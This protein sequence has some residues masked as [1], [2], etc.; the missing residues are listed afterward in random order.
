MDAQTT[1]F[2]A[3][4]SRRRRHISMWVIAPVSSML[5]AVATYSWHK[6]SDV[7]CTNNL[8]ALYFE[9]DFDRALRLDCA[10]LSQS[11]RAAA[12]YVLN[13]ERAKASG[14]AEDAARMLGSHPN[15]PYALFAMAGALMFE[16][17][18]G[19][20]ALKYARLAVAKRPDDPTFQWLL[21]DN[22]RLNGQF[23]QAEQVLRRSLLTQKSALLLTELAS[24]HFDLAERSGFE[25]PDLDRALATIAQATALDSK[26]ARAPYIAGQFLYRANQP[27]R[28]RAY[29][30]KAAD[31]TWSDKIRYNYWDAV[32]Q[33]FA[34]TKEQ[35][36]KIVRDDI[37]RYE[38]AGKT[39]E[40]TYQGAAY[41][42]QLLGMPREHDYYIE[43]L[44]KAFP[45]TLIGV[46][47]R[48]NRL[49][50]SIASASLTQSPSP[51]SRMAVLKELQSIAATQGLGPSRSID[52]A[53]LELADLLLESPSGNERLLEDLGRKLI[54]DEQSE[55]Q[56]AA[57]GIIAL[58]T[59]RPADPLA[60][61]EAARR[62]Q[63][64]P[65]YMRKHRME[66]VEA[67]LFASSVGAQVAYAEGFANYRRGQLDLAVQNLNEALKRDPGNGKS[68]GL[69][70]DIAQKRGDYARAE[71]W[72][73]RCSALPADPK[74]PCYNSISRMY[75]ARH[76]SERGLDLYLASLKP[77]IV[78]AVAQRVQPHVDAS[79]RRPINFNL[80]SLDGKH[81]SSASTKGKVV[82][83]IYWGIWC[84][85]ARISL[86][87]IFSYAER[88]KG[89]NDVIFV[90]V[91][92][93]R[94]LL[95]ATQWLKSQN[96]P[97]T[98]IDPA[99]IKASNIVSVP[100][101]LFLDRRGREAYRLR[102]LVGQIDTEFGKR[103]ANLRSETAP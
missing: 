63:G 64:L 87:E 81:I 82:V 47:E 43:K 10:N 100:T 83:L 13:E 16:P 95:K 5:L 88:F 26:F 59:S 76:G 41:F 56:L 55:P 37:A 79:A 21:A 4:E 24:V 97:P 50:P 96:P 69:L 72:Y 84:D 29:M 53:R 22:L 90:S 70:G 54:S 65:D 18:R 57:S 52:T 91:N 30:A 3:K 15:D 77:K 49:L 27:D 51:A 93:G 20:E 60:A 68:M 23:A 86:P 85:V 17:E 34:L 74:L 28:A 73:V 98:A 46:Q 19:V 66:G 38:R 31:L 61:Q 36:I 62:L 67:Q 40:Y 12:W 11:T 32:R 2:E 14:A 25:G 99:L 45:G 6:V 92:D 8:Q 94:D 7:R 33:S 71:Y 42:F 58:A 101:T 1:K 35:K 44:L 80:T 75:V 9:D 103:I 48:L 78:A 89:S 102:G 39:S